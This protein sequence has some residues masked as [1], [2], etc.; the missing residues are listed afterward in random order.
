[1]NSSKS[2]QPIILIKS[3]PPLTC[4]RTARRISSAP[5]PSRK[6]PERSGGFRS[7]FSRRVQLVYGTGGS[8]QENAWA[9]ARARYDAEI[10]WYRGNSSI[11]VIADTAFD[12][13]LDPDRN[14]ILYGNAD[15]H[16]SWQALWDGSVVVRRDRV[17]VGDRV[18]SGP[19]LGVLSVRPR[20]GSDVALV[21]IVAPT[22]ETGTRVLD[23]RP[24]LTPGVAYPDLTVFDGRRDDEIVVGAGFFGAD[25]SVASGEFAW[26][27]PD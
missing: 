20:P 7:A 12:A 10:L 19:S 3:A 18:L 24:V 21:G 16:G 11:D 23:L 8:A 27:D 4:S 9:L 15:T 2:W 13:S 26:S 5:D 1:M 22:G 6:G 17:E 25:W 14:V